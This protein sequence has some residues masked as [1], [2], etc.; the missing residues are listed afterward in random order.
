MLVI[1]ATKTSC[2]EGG[3]RADMSIVQLV[4]VRI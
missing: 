2:I 1:M 4:K 3:S